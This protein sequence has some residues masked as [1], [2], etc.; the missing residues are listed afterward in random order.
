[1]TE[2]SENKNAKI[3][4]K[5]TFDEYRAQTLPNIAKELASLKA[6]ARSLFDAVSKKRE[7]FA[8]KLNEEE[9]A[10]TP[11]EAEKKTASAPNVKTETPIAEVKT[12]E[13]PVEEKKETVLAKPKT[14]TNVPHRTF[15]IEPEKKKPDY[16]NEPRRIYIPPEKKAPEKKVQ[17][18]VFDNSTQQRQPRPQNSAPG[19]ARPMRPG[20]K[21]QGGYVAPAV[22][23]PNKNQPK[24][25]KNAYTGDEKNA[26]SKYD[27]KKSGQF[28]RFDNYNNFKGTT[29]DDNADEIFDNTRVRNYKAKKSESN[30]SQAIKIESAVVNSEVFSIKHLYE[31]RGKTGT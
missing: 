14:N 9:K 24:T 28:G 26:P 20:A 1:M 22:I 8:A 12:E 4:V 21:P 27:L 29:I 25:K 11:K 19:G 2:N 13:K 23:M 17:T 5:K 16:S 15:A 3:S 30:K 31:K 7:E 6:K 10:V 18:R